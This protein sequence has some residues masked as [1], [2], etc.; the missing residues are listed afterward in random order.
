[1]KNKL[2]IYLGDLDHFVEGNRYSLP[3]N[4]ACLA[5]YCK[6]LYGDEVEI[7]LFKHPEK[8]IQKIREEPPHIL[9]LSFY[10]WNSN[11]SLK[12]VRYCKTISP[13]TITVIGGPS[14]ARTTDKYK[15]MLN[16]ASGLDIV[17]LDQGEKSF[18][19]IIGA[20][21]SQGIEKLF[22]NEIPG[23]A[24]RLK[25][26]KEPVRGNLVEDNE[27][28]LSLIPSPY[29]TGWLDPFLALGFLPLLETTRGCPY[30]CTYCGWGDKFYCRLQVKDEEMVYEELRYIQKYSKT[31]E[32]SI[33]DSNFGIMGERDKK[34]ALF[35]KKMHEK[36]GFPVVTDYASSKTKTSQ[37]IE[38]MSIIADI[39]GSFYFG[40]QTLT[41]D[42]LEKCAR[43]N[44]SL[45]TVKELSNVAKEK[46]WGINVDLIF[47]LPGETA[48]SFFETISQLVSLRILQPS[49]YNLRLLPGT[50]LAEEER[51]K[52]QY[53]TRFRP[54][55]NRYGEYELAPGKKPER[56]IEVEEI[57]YESNSFDKNDFMLARK[58]GF[59]SELLLA[60]GALSET[61][62]FLSTRGINTAKIF[63]FILQKLKKCPQMSKLFREYERLVQNELFTSE[64]K[65]IKSICKNDKEW[66]DLL[67]HRGNY[68]KINLGFVGYCLLENNAI[69]KEVESLIFNYIKN[70]LT[71]DQLE[72]YRAILRFDRAHRIISEKKKSRL[73]K[74]DL[75]KE[76][77]IEEKNDYLKW[78]KNDY[79]GN[80]KDYKFS[81]PVKYS[82]EIGKYGN[83]Q[84]N[85]DELNNFSEFNFY[86]RI[87][88]KRTPIGLRRLSKQ[89]P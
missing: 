83:F 6:K 21:L 35:M 73:K 3:L 86:E 64:K 76:I 36:H 13:S 59:L 52:Y 10:M 75:K 70:K 89:T 7:K 57:A 85:I 20:V 55:N 26:I 71:P 27:N 37:S 69:I 88:I 11:L 61:L 28:M 53:Q 45:D 9:A 78:I 12:I 66:N 68:F 54:F 16:Q 19:N 2:K 49:I 67:M 23:C 15:K 62:I 46:N 42:V 30:A 1:M 84:K 38:I 48:Q 82:Y 24:S 44:I 5:S 72:N 50:K 87:L 60:Y 47:G 77:I 58:F 63:E 32:L 25:N 81:A 29:L 4:I 79:K 43:K 51:E 56:I 65:L 74:F 80:L 33:N 8:L 18:S 22:A 14:V 34:I 40:L 31:N 39:T 41:Q 17:V